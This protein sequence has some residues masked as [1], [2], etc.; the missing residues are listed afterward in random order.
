MSN[1]FPDS[2]YLESRPA[3]K[4]G[5]GGNLETVVCD[6]ATNAI[7]S[8]SKVDSLGCYKVPDRRDCEEIGAVGQS[9]I[10]EDV[11]PLD[12]RSIFICIRQYPYALTDTVSRRLLSL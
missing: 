9:D 6:L 5:S 11:M 1:S 7:G 2:S 12:F 4:P 10:F 3:P 8:A